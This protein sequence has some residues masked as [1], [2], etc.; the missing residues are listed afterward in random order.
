MLS[1]EEGNLPALAILAIVVFLIIL[2]LVYVFP[3]AGKYVMDLIR[4]AFGR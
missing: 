3:D 2:A 4:T 1:K